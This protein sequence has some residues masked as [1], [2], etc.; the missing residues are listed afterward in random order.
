MKNHI[1]SLGVVL[2]TLGSF[3]VWRFLTELNWADKNAFLQGKGV[4]RI[5][6]PEAEDVRKFKLQLNLSRLGLGLIILGGFLQII[7][8]YLTE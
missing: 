4:L 6:A 8:N 1:S 5:P 3:L 7:S 2:T